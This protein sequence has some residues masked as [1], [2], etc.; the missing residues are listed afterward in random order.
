[1][2]QEADAAKNQRRV[3]DGKLP[4]YETR[5]LI[6]HTP[7]ETVTR[8][9]ANT[10]QLR[11]SPRQHLRRGHIRRLPDGRKI[12]VQAAVVGSVE[13]GRIDKSYFVGAA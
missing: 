13:K 11:A 8:S 2:A 10:G 7:R 9:E 3:R 6:I 4:I 1:V 12:W 5:V